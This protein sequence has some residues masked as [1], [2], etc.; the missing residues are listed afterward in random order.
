MLSNYIKIAIRNLRRQMGYS[1][2]NVSGLAIGMACCLL[3]I[4][5]IQDELGYDQYHEH[6]DRMYRVVDGGNATTPP[7]LGALLFRM[8]FA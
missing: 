8:F 3:I 1:A 4:L 2:I 7:A 6:A 5:Y